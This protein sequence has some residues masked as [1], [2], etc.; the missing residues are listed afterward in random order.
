MRLRF[1]FLFFSLSLLRFFNVELTIYRCRI[2]RFE[3]KLERIG[4]FVSA[5]ERICWF[6]RKKRGYVRS[7]WRLQ[8]KLNYSR[9][10][11]IHSQCM[12]APTHTNTYVS[13]QCGGHEFGHIPLLLLQM[14]FQ[15]DLAYMRFW[16]THRGMSHRRA[17]LAQNKMQSRSECERE[18]KGEGERD[19]A[20]N[21]CANV[22][23]CCA[24]RQR[25]K[26]KKVTYTQMIERE[27]QMEWEK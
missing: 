1:R 27:G 16:M 4:L 11:R 8:T 21:K 15:I 18:G 22:G 20:Y 12:Y 19:W 5:W 10:E 17:C 24:L 2:R 23:K 9:T 6:V 14:R 26:K 25:V 13:T 7:W 3:Q